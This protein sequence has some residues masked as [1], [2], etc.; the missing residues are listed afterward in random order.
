MDAALADLAEVQQRIARIA[1]DLA[2]H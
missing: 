1:A 2:T